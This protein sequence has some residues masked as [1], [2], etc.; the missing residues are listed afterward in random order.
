M[1]SNRQSILK[2][3]IY[4]IILYLCHAKQFLND[5]EYLPVY[6]DIVSKNKTLIYGFYVSYR[7][8][9]YVCSSLYRFFANFTILFN[10]KIG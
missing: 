6:T 10:R 2:Y 7:I 8:L 1:L 4:L 5:L 9:H 3:R